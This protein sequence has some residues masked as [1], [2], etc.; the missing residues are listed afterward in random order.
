MAQFEQAM[1][2]QKSQ[3][4]NVCY[5]GRVGFDHLPMSHSALHKTLPSLGSKHQLALTDP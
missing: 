4:S 2:G 3:L 1:T 5:S